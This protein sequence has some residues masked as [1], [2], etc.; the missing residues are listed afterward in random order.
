[1]RPVSPSTTRCASSSSSNQAAGPEHVVTI[2]VAPVTLRVGAEDL[3]RPR[4]SATIGLA[5]QARQRRQVRRALGEPELLI[6]RPAPVVALATPCLATPRTSMLVGAP[7][8]ECERGAVIRAVATIHRQHRLVV[9]NDRHALEQRPRS[10]P[11]VAEQRGEIGRAADFLCPRG[12]LLG[13]HHARTPSAAQDSGKTLAPAPALATAFA[14]SRASPR[15]TKNM[16]PPAPAPAAFPPS[17]PAFVA[18]VSSSA[19]SAVRMPGSSACWC[20]QFS[21]NRAPTRARSAARRASTIALP[22][23][24]NPRRAPVT[25]GSPRSY[26]PIT[27]EIV[28]PET[29]DLLV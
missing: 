29:R 3:A 26:A 6:A 16:Q 20:F 17:A 8:I 9:R 27:R 23:S 28:S 15:M 22:V 25:L 10:L 24:F 13:G 7:G 1:M 11:Q 4:R 2:G 12:E 18:A 5:A 19:I 21:L 14:A